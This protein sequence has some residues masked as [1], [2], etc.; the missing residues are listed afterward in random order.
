MVL[1]DDTVLHSCQDSGGS[2]FAFSKSSSSCSNEV[3][4]MMFAQSER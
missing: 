3:S 2:N 1:G 4:K